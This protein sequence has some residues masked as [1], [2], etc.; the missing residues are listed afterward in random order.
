M[1]DDAV[2]FGFVC[3]Q[4]AGRS[5]MSAAFAERE[6]R[7]RGLDDRV[8][9]VTGGTHPAEE[10]H[11]EVVEAMG[12]LGIDLS[13]RVP[14]EVST[15]ELNACDIVATMGCSTLTLA[16]GVEARDWALDDP[17]GQEIERVR[18]IRDEIEE[19]VVALFDE[20]LDEA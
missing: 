5:Q 18:E 8:E 1:N 2:T 9:V 14:R 12:E 10:V 17:H 13:D 6:R 7:E 4:N 20:F 15:A 11:P 16:D 3:V 19:R